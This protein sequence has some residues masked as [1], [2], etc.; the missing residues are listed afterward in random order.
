MIWCPNSA[1]QGWNL[2]THCA[3]VDTI[4]LRR[5]VRSHPAGCLKWMSG[6]NILSYV[7]SS[8][9]GSLE[10][11]YSYVWKCSPS[12]WF[13]MDEGALYGCHNSALSTASSQTATL[14]RSSQFIIDHPSSPY[15]LRSAQDERMTMR[16][17]NNKEHSWLLIFSVYQPHV[18]RITSLLTLVVLV[19][20]VILR[21]TSCYLSWSSLFLVSLL[22]S[23]LFFSP[24][25]AAFKSLKGT[26]AW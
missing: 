22:F 3:D 17:R 16:K 11:E 25:I 19:F 26:R 24:F 2:V 1:Y 8:S 4:F 12:L 7:M 21:L 20:L 6:Y 9:T 18:C 5:A 13:I 15:L 14:K 10:D 23:S